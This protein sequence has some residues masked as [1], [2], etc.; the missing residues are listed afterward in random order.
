MQSVL[1]EVGT[2]VEKEGK[3]NI[4][5]PCGDLVG[6]ALVHRHEGGYSSW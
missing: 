4:E 6:W 5:S 2:R 1:T 3:E